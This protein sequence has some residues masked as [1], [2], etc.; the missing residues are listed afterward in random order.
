MYSIESPIYK[1]FVSIFQPLKHYGSNWFEPLDCLLNPEPDHQFGSAI[2]KNL[3]LNFRFSSWW[4]RFELKF[5]TGL[6]HHYIYTKIVV[7]TRKL[8]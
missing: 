5:G 7:L 8:S 6:F 1:G 4:F 2:F 3:E